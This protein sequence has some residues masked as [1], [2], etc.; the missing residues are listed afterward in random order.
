MFTKTAAGDR[1]VLGELQIGPLRD[2]SVCINSLSLR[3][4]KINIH[5]LFPKGRK[6]KSSQIGFKDIKKH[7]SECPKPRTIQCQQLLSKS[8][9]RLCAMVSVI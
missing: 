5:T 4:E 1:F 2:V 7:N 3:V 6:L 9:S 8:C